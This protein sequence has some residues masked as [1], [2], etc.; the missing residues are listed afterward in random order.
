MGFRE[1]LGLCARLVSPGG[2]VAASEVVW[3]VAAPPDEIRRWW[4]AQYP[5]I[6]SVADKAAAVW[7]AGL[8]IVGHFTLPRRAWTLH[9]YA[10]VKARL[11]ELRR[12]WI[13]DA[14]GLDVIAEIDAEIAM[15]ERWGHTHGYEFFVARRPQEWR[16]QSRV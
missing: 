16:G 7:S 2:Y 11:E 10:P 14:A 9:F 4:D 6:A 13:G 5:D 3:T 15:Y 1:G 8:E 12:A